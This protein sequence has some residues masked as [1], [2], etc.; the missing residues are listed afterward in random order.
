MQ[1]L[2]KRHHYSHAWDYFS[3]IL[4]MQSTMQA[5]WGFIHIVRDGKEQK[6]YKTLAEQFSIPYFIFSSLHDIKALEWSCC[7]I[8]SIEIEHID[9]EVS[10]KLLSTNITLKSWQ[11]HD[12]QELMKSLNGLGYEFH[13]YQKPGSYM[14]SW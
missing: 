5:S 4:L 7:A 1:A 12:M 2:Q 9:Q 6:K 8:Y 3:K 10:Q 11:E 14:R 13:E